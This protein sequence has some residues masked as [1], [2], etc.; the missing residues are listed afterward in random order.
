MNFEHTY[1]TIKM[2]GNQC[3]KIFKRCKEKILDTHVK[4]LYDSKGEKNE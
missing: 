4:L 1:L 2:I 3:K